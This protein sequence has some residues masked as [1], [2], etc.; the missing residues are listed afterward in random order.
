M[1]S[2][3]VAFSGKFQQ[4]PEVIR[5]DFA[6]STNSAKIAINNLVPKVNLYSA[7]YDSLSASLCLSQL[8]SFF[9]FYYSTAHEELCT[10]V[11]KKNFFYC[12]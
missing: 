2:W 6:R 11:A 9:S 5:Q 10:S 4:K 8:Q 7:L 1:A 3:W 12:L